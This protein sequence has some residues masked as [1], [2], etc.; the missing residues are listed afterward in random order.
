MNFLRRSRPA[1]RSFFS[2][3]L[4]RGARDGAPP[5]VP[6]PT[7]PCSGAP[8]FFGAARPRLPFPRSPHKAGFTGG[9]RSYYVDRY[10]VQHFRRRGAHR[11][12]ENPRTVLLVVVVGTTGVLTIYYG[13]LETVPYTKRTHFVLLSPR[14]ER[15]LGE[16][17]FEQLKAELKERILPPTHPDSIRVRL[18]AKDIVEALQRGLRQPERTWRDPEYTSGVAMVAEPAQEQWDPSR[19]SGWDEEGGSRGEQ[20]WTGKDE[21]L[22]D[23]W[24]QQSRK[25]GKVRGLQPATHHLEGL[26]WEV[27]VVRNPITNAM[28]LPG[29][30][31]IVF[32]GLLDHFRSDAEIA[33]VIGHEVL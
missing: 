17:Q 8:V 24:A 3:G 22:D 13:N 18:I 7:L 31:I 33:T 6:R 27:V 30:K 2:G 9:R 10:Q 5:V 4:G 26:N 15:Q 21:M 25:A 1:I 28:C 32:T 12:F 14:V 11:W 19:A 20:R 23:K 29:G 16:T